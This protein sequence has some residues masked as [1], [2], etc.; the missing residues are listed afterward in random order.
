MKNKLCRMNID[1]AFY[2]KGN[3]EILSANKHFDKLCTKIQQALD[4]IVDDVEIDIESFEE[5]D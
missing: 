4:S 2:L 1:V 5:L 3:T